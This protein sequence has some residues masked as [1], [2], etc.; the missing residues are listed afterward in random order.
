M[1]KKGKSVSQTVL[2]AKTETVTLYCYVNGNRF[3]RLSIIIPESIAIHTITKLPQAHDVNANNCQ[4]KINRDI[5]SSS[6]RN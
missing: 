2:Q 1:D 5:S 3:P 4:F 6:R